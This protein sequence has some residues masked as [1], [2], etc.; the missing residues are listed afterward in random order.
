MII[1][2]RNEWYTHF[3]RKF[4]SNVC[5]LLIFQ[6]RKLLTT[7]PI[8]F[9]RFPCNN[10]KYGYKGNTT[11]GLKIII[12]RLLTAKKILPIEHLSS[13]CVYLLYT[14]YLSLY[15]PNQ[16]MFFS[17]KSILINL[18]TWNQRS[19]DL[20]RVLKL[21]VENKLNVFTN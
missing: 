5:A 19:K 11:R 21:M 4:I 3:C 8:F 20:Y 15:K 17:D 9:V 10:Q 14:I 13:K 18:S 7:L 16:K 12:I 2:I 6:Q 1:W